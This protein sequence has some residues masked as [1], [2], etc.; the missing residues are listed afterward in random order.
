L[1]TQS[2]LTAACFHYDGKAWGTKNAC[3]KLQSAIRTTWA[4][5]PDDIWAAGEDGH[6]ARYRPELDPDQWEVL[7]ARPDASKY[8]TYLIFGA[9]RDVVWVPVGYTALMRYQP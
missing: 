6:I 1:G 5:G 7:D 3:M 9:E 8:S 2:G 4:S